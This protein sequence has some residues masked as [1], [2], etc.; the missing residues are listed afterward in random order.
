[1]QSRLTRQILFYL[2]QEFF[3]VFAWILLVVDSKKVNHLTFF[4]CTANYSARILLSL[5]IERLLIQSSF[6][7]FCRCTWNQ[8]KN[9]KNLIE[10]ASPGRNFWWML[11]SKALSLFPQFR[12]FL[13][14]IPSDY[15]ALFACANINK[16]KLSGWNISH[17]AGI[18][19]DRVIFCY[20]S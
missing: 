9:Q 14:L 3:R 8:K 2:W 15:L 11:V 4:D 5:N 18:S 12:I 10:F 1:M 20:R 17:C 6:F 7:Y 13:K 19:L 16:R